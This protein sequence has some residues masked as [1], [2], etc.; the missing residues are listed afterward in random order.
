MND[1]IRLLQRHSSVRQFSNRPVDDETLRALIRAGQSAST[2]NH[3]QAYTIIRVRDQAKKDR[4]A[5]L[6]GDQSHVATCPLFL[7]FCADLKRLEAAC[8]AQ[9]ETMCGGSVETFLLATIDAALVAQN[10]MVAAESL[11][12]GGVFIGGLR[13]NPREV[14]ALLNIPAQVYPVFGMCL[15]Y[16]AQRNATKPRLPLSLVLKEDCYNNDDDSERLAQYDREIRE[17]YRVR[18]NGAR[19]NSWSEGVSAMLREKQRPH[20]RQFLAEQGFELK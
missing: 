5:V 18:S 19:D 4:L 10:V 6:A 7:V 16:P 14:C 8:A 15:G 11:E 1:T 13:N 20:M 2:S 9:G 17:Y 12:L 3:I